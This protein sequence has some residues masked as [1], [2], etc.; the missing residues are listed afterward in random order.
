MKGQMGFYFHHQFVLVQTFGYMGEKRELPF[1]SRMLT[2]EVPTDVVGSTPV[3]E[4]LGDK[5]STLLIKAVRQ[6]L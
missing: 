4:S 1:T 6:Y 2:L 5:E 3:Q